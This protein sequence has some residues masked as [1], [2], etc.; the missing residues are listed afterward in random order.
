MVSFR[1]VVVLALSTSTLALPSFGSRRSNNVEMSVV[2]TLSEPPA[3]WIKDEKTKLDK[4]E[5][6]MRL[7]IHLKQPDMDKFHDMALKVPQPVVP[8]STS[9]SWASID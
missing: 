9:R 3:G 7:R 5:A 4:D 6:M 2:Q 1:T 8:E